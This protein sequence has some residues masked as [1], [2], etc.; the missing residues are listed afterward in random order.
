[1]NRNV[2]CWV[3][4]PDTLSA[5]KRSVVVALLA[6]L[7]LALLL[8][9]AAA[10]PTSILLDDFESG[11][12]AWRTNDSTVANQEQLATLCGIYPTSMRPPGGGAQAAMLDFLPA[13]NAWASVSLSID[14][15]TWH[16]SQIGQLSMWIRGAERDTSVAVTL[17]AKIPTPQGG[18]QDRSYTQQV[19]LSPTAWQHISLRLFGFQTRDGIALDDE[20]LPH[21]YLL[22]FVKTG[23]WKRTR[24]YVDRIEAR[25]LIFSDQP[26]L[27]LAD[28]HKPIVVDLRQELG[29]CLSQVGFGVSRDVAASN[30]DPTKQRRMATHAADLRPCVGRLRTADYYDDSQQ[31]FDLFSLNEALKWLTGI[32]IRPLLCLDMPDRDKTSLDRAA[33]WEQLQLTATKVAELNREAKM[34]PYY[35]LVAPPAPDDLDQVGD[36]IMSY[37]RFFSL[38]EAAD[39]KAVIGGPGLAVVNRELIEETAGAASMSFFSYHLMLPGPT[40]PDDSRL[41]SAATTGA[42]SSLEWGYEQIARHLAST[43]HNSELFITKW[44][45]EQPWAADTAVRADQETA[46]ALFL[47]T[48]ALSA[49]RFVDKLLWRDLSDRTSGLLDEQGRPKPAYWAAWLVSTY[50]P[51]G[52]SYRA[53]IE[54]PDNLLIV[55]ITTRTAA[56]IFVVNRSPWQTSVQMEVVGAQTPAIVREHRLEPGQ[57]NAVQHRNLS[58]SNLQKIEFQSSGI[59]VLQFIPT[60]AQ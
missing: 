5:H 2:H 3:A 40:W 49:S 32:G 52:A 23:T 11:I 43:I 53:Y 28:E 51:R 9:P 21:L 59:S 60:Q 33:V 20:T 37:Q 13:R 6:T 39:H 15:P 46:D 12:G 50:A 22:Q 56:N 17:R 1:M 29:R 18:F 27:P 47:A 24:F 55:A 25:P 8:A 4:R 16:N 10:E 35:E 54:R 45:V 36:L 26:P 38:I 42:L 34:A 14:G 19:Q 57:A 31:Q 30:A 7:L 58:L 44:G 48:S 41:A